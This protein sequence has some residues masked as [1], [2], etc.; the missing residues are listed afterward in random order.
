MPCCKGPSRSNPGGTSGGV[1]IFPYIN[2]SEIKLCHAAE[3]HPEGTSG[4]L[5]IF[6]YINNS[7]IKLWDAAEVPLGG[8]SGVHFSLHVPCCII[9]A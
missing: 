2:A 3:V 8:T 1:R 4:G 7:G 5:H 9:S 6:H